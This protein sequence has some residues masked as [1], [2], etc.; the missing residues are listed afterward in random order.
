MT[1]TPDQQR[2]VAA[3]C[4][5]PTATPQNTQVTFHGDWS[6]RSLPCGCRTRMRTR[7]RGR[8]EVQE[9][10]RCNGWRSVL[11]EETRW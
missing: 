11:W 8:I 1:L 10:A 7:G 5:V 6:Y 3:G 2:L 4:T 9:L